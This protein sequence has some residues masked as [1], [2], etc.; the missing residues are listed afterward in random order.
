GAAR[1]A[2]E[3]R[4][5]RVAEPTALG[6]RALDALRLSAHPAIATLLRASLLR[7]AASS[8]AA[9]AAALARYHALLLHARDA[10]AVGRRLGRSAVRAAVGEDEAQLVLWGLLPAGDDDAELVLDD[11]PRVRAL[12]A[13]AAELARAGDAKRAALDALLAEEA[14]ALVF[15]GSRA[16]ARWLRGALA[17]RRVAWCIGDEAGLGAARV[18]RQAVLGWFGP[19]AREAPAR[20]LVTTDVAAEGLD[21]QR[22][23]R[24]IHYDLPWTAAR[25]AQREGRARRLGAARAAVEVIRFEPSPAVERRLR[26]CRLLLRKARLP[27][28]L[29]L[30]SDDDEASAARAGPWR[31]RAELLEA[32][33]TCGADG[34]ASVRASRAATLVGWVIERAGECMARGVLVVRADGS[35]REA[36]A[37]VGAW[38]ARAAAGDG[39]PR[40]HAAEAV[41]A[42]PRPVTA[43]LR[44]RLAAL[45]RTAW[46]P[47]P[48]HADGTAV[49]RRLQRLIREAARRRDAVRLAVLERG[50]HA[51]SLAP[52]AGEAL[53]LATLARADDDTMLAWCR[54]Q[55]GTGQV[56][57]AIPRIVAVLS[58]SP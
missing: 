8:P 35:V 29:G 5:L 26:Q 4:R 41:D 40:D 20:H 21:L 56:G 12:A 31:W 33:G 23:T 54:R 46:T 27:E 11:L 42:L 38:L 37:R 2:R 24:V 22:A 51:A 45:H 9:L 16:T 13:R 30:A 53:A 28:A 43:E 57:A 6:P 48:R 14:P 36:D 44:A 18:P 7:A 52:T 47:A 25:L 17:H 32:V 50:L 19:G 10:A 39:P 1:P 3:E 34:S 15:T 49:V 55:A 58:L